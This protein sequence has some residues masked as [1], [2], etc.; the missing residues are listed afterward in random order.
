MLS[1]LDLGCFVIK[2]NHRRLLDGMM[3]LCGVPPSRFRAICSAID[4]L[5]KE[6]W[7]VVYEEMVGQKGLDPQVCHLL[8]HR[9]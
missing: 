1:D 9:T 7:S 6:P 5:D 4:K 3:H 8:S 2:V